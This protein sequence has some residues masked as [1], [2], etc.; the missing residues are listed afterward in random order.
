MMA[1]AA[2]DPYW[3]A[4][5]RRETMDHAPAAAAIEDKCATCHMPMARYLAH[6]GGASGSV[7]AHL[8]A[9]RAAT[10]AAL[11]AHDGVSCAVCHQIEGDNLDTPASFTGGFVVD[12]GNALGERVVFGPFAVDS[13]RQRIMRSASGFEPT[14]GSHV[15][16][17]A[18]CGSCHTLY[19]H[20]LDADGNEVGELPE[21]TPY[22]EWRH[23][24]YNGERSCQ[25][26]HMPAVEGETAVTGVLGE[27]R[28]DVSRHVFRGGNFL[29]P[30]LL[31]RYRDEL[32]VVALPQELEATAARS[33]E[34]LR[35]NSATLMVQRPTVAGG[36]LTFGVLVRNLA[37]HKL[38]T[39]Y[40]SRRAWL[41]VTVQ[42]DEDRVV[43]ESGRLRRNGS[44]VGNDNDDDPARYEPHH[45]RIDGP[46]LVQV[47]EA[48]MEHYAGGPTT[49]LL[50]GV[51]YLKD[52]R[53][54]PRGFDKASAD[55]DVAVYGAAERDDDFGGGADVVRYAIDVTGGT[56]PFTIEV[57]LLYQPIS[58]RWAQNLTAYDAPEPR[59]FVRYYD[60]MAGATHER[61]ATATRTV[62]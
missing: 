3:Q 2:R 61:L 44:I 31:N 6:L 52:N 41:H 49:G 22:L 7:F 21:Q 23:S 19:T 46:E 43:F 39:A 10:P 26:C 59:R 47:Y 50:N 4:G 62:P 54:L 38:P 11:L 30:R 33:A 51:G 15:R 5:V 29:M 58:F 13:G 57:E 14:E 45:A 12:H 34:H 9:G 36:M 37:G 56:A 60:S 53:L 27:R 35:T 28:S 40:P 48:V 1:N 32:G 25:D 18:L 42:D 16:S 17:S 55:P 20:A 8:P 24:A